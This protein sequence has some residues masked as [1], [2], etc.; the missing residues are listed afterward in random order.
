MINIFQLSPR[1][2]LEDRFTALLS[3]VVETDPSVGSAWTSHL[4]AGSSENLGDFE[5]VTD[6]PRYPGER[7]LPDLAI[8]TTRG[9]ILCEHKIDS[10][11]ED[12]Q[13][14]R[15]LQIAERHNAH[16]VVI[17]QKTCRIS[18][19]NLQHPRYLQPGENG[20]VHFYWEDLFPIVSRSPVKLSRDFARF[21]SEDL[22]MRPFED[23]SLGRLFHDP[24][25]IPEFRA[26]WRRVKEWGKSVGAD[27]VAAKRNGLG[28]GLRRPATGVQLIYCQPVQRMSPPERT[29]PGPYMRGNV[30]FSSDDPRSELTTLEHRGSNYRHGPIVIRRKRRERV[31]GGK[32][33]L[34]VLAPLSSIFA[35]HRADTENRLLDFVQ[36]C[37]DEA[38]KPETFDA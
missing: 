10:A 28:Q 34:Q 9:T 35:E 8:H 7:Y 37:L 18:K 20:R 13:V 27:M 5:S 12:T 29:F 15:Y 24:S 16:L 17:S 32:G 3:Y 31:K 33:D 14:E 22:G 11:L 25:A 4:L 30:F 38:A 2:D 1:L 36:T 26:A 6:H 19:E 21:I 23:P